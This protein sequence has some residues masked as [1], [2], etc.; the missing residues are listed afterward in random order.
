MAYNTAEKQA[1]YNLKAF[2][3][4]QALGF[5]EH[6]PVEFELRQAAPPSTMASKWP[7]TAC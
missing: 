2:R 7:P 5:V 6:V 1:D 3:I 4:G